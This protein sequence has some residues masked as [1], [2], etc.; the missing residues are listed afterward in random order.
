MKNIG[1]RPALDVTT[2]FDEPFSGLGGRKAITSML[3]FRR[4]AFMAPG[5]TFEQYVDPL[6]EYARRNEPMTIAATVS[7]RDRAGTTYKE[8][9]S[10]DLRVY[11]ELGQARVVY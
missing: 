1:A 6:Y 3:V 9:I 11:L 4:V 2:V 7:Y 5:K 10:H 8:R